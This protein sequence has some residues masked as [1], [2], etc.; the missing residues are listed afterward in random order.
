VSAWIEKGGPVMW[1]LLALSL[2]AATVIF[3][4]ALFW[5]RERRRDP[6]VLLAELGPEACVEHAERRL[7]RGLALLDTVVTA[8]PL[9]GILGTVLGV[10][11]CFELLSARALPDPLAISGGVAEALITTATGLTIA[12]AVL[13][14]YNYLRARTR[15]RLTEIEAAVRRPLG[16]TP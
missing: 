7:T 4:R 9:L 6:R 16:A 14:P 15:A 8:A 13:L 5:S 11:Q 2:V 1:P 12:V 10:I 3:E